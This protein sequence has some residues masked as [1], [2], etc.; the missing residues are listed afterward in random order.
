[1]FEEVKSKIQ[2]LNSGILNPDNAPSHFTASQCNEMAMLS[3]HL[4]A[5]IND[6]NGSDKIESDV[7]SAL[8]SITDIEQQAKNI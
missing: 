5:V 7:K 3:L 6:F 2:Y 8:N 4:N 1:M